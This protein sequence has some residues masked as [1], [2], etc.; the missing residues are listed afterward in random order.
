VL[1]A[2]DLRPVTRVDAIVPGAKLNLDL[3]RSSAG[4]RRSAWETRASSCSSTVRRSRR[5][6]PWATASTCGS[7][8]A[9]EGATPGRRLR[10][11]SARK[12][13]ASGVMPRYDVA[14]PADGEPLN[15]VVSPQLVIRRVFD[16]VDGFERAARVAALQ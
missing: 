1:T 9:T 6:R 4:S 13:T 11:A 16:A 2:D 12:S 3:A 8:S 10:S 7:A 15:G 5:R 14:F